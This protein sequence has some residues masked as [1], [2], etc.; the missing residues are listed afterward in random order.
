MFV[1]V[2]NEILI[3]VLTSE[4]VTSGDATCLDEQHEG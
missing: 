3:Y 1:G 4:G 2:K